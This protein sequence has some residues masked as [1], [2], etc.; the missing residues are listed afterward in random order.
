MT[1]ALEEARLRSLL[2]RVETL[3]DVASTLDA[4][5]ERRK[6]LLEVTRA[7]L[8]DAEPVRPIIAAKLL[9]ISEKTVRAWVEAGVLKAERDRPRLLLDLASVHT[10]SHL[11][12]ELRAAGQDRDLLDAIWHRLIDD[13]VLDRDD[14]A[15]S[16]DQMRQGQGRVLRHR[17]D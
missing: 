13:S 6:R 2:K 15:E 10:V 9:G 11:L 14:L 5:D 17:T 16:L 1:I 4:N 3:E 7:D 8:D 12:N